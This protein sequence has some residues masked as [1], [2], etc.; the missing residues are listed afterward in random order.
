MLALLENPQL[1][2]HDRFTDRMH[3]VLPLAEELVSRE[4]LVDPPQADYDHL[5]GHITR[6]CS[7]PV[8]EWFTYV[9]S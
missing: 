6:E 2:E 4:S 8:E 3:A 7:Q 5:S 9:A 1:H